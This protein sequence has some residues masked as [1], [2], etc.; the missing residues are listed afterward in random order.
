[1]CL[2]GGC[3]Y[4]FVYSENVDGRDIYCVRGGSRYYVKMFTCTVM[5]LCAKYVYS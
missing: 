1:M 4:V 2:V 3:R 5:L